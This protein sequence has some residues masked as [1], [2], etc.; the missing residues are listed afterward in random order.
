MTDT[1]VITKI[2]SSL[3][4]KYRNFC[5]AWLSTDENRQT[6]YNLTA[7]L[8]D[9]EM[10]MTAEG[11]TAWDCRQPNSG[12]LPFRNR[13]VTNDKTVFVVSDAIYDILS[14]EIEQKLK[15]TNMEN[16]LLWVYGR[17]TT[18]KQCFSRHPEYE[19]LGHVNSKYLTAV[20]NL[21]SGVELV[22][23]KYFFCEGCIYG[24]QYKLPF[25]QVTKKVGKAGGLIHYDVC[26]PMPEQSVKGC[27]NF[28]LFKDDYSSFKFVRFFKHKN[29]VLSFFEEVVNICKNKFGNNVQRL[30]V[31]KCHSEDG[32][33]DFR[34]ESIAPNDE[35][36]SE[37][38][39]DTSQVGTKS[40]REKN[41]PVWRYLKCTRN[42]GL[43]FAK[44]RIVNSNLCA[45]LDSYFANDIEDRR[46]VTGY[47]LNLFGNCTV[48]RSKKQNNVSLRSSEAE[49][50][51]VSECIKDC[52]YVY[53]LLEESTLPLNL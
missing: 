49:Y 17:T 50:V 27:R 43:V 8:L 4:D 35:V 28:D 6:I 16:R 1:A 19:H 2:L 40:Q 14:N 42:F 26:G 15:F 34:F 7:S 44:E 23:H 24:K 41:F 37:E 5:Q 45:Y 9:E 39:S 53:Q 30:R 38:T 36:E 29:E 11:H 18:F 31:D 51:A 32:D 47:C 12:K 3:P 33:G 25:K 46:S 22:R 52:K 10:T 20:M 13:G 21:V 48:C